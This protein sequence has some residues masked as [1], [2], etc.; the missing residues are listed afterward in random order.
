MALPANVNGDL[1]GV[2]THENTTAFPVSSSRAIW[3]MPQPAKGKAQ[4]GLRLGIFI[5]QPQDVW[6]WIWRL[7]WQGCGHRPSPL[8]T[9]IS[10]LQ[11]QDDTGGGG[12]RD[13]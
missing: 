7:S 5:L 1:V 12:K 6:F 8:H 10:L 3:H 11:F 2:C 9:A 4:L 13:L